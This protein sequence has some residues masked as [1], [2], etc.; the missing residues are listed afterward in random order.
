MMTMTTTNIDDDDNINEDNME[1]VDENVF[2]PKSIKCH[3]F[4]KP[5]ARPDLNDDGDD[6][7]NNDVKDNNKE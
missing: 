4:S 7:N 1:E 3:T 5:Q 2:P 6:D